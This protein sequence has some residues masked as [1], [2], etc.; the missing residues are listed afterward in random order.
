MLSYSSLTQKYVSSRILRTVSHV[1]P[2]FQTQASP[3]AQ[4]I[5]F[6]EAKGLTPPEIDV[7]VKQ[8]S[9]NQIAGP[10]YQP[11]Y[12]PVYGPSPH[13]WDWRDYFVQSTYHHN[14]TCADLLFI[15]DYCCCLWDCH[16]RCSSVVQSIDTLSP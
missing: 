15:K 13:R 2:K 7:A 16:L 4:R 9:M 11:P 10:S 8:A 12:V 5:Q 14:E 3:L 1:H 6:L